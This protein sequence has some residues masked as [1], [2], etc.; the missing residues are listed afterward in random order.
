M[1]ATILYTNYRGEKADRRITPLWIWFGR[2]EFHGS[3]E[4]W[5]LHAYCH[6]KKAIRDFSM[7]NIHEWRP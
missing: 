6:E 3:L 1:D 7:S 5:L 4:Q 2:N